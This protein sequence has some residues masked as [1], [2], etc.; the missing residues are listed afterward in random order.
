MKKLEGNEGRRRKTFLHPAPSF[1]SHHASER[2]AMRATV[3]KKGKRLGMSLNM[4]FTTHFSH[5]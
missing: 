3:R 2:G 5:Y 4:N 1:N